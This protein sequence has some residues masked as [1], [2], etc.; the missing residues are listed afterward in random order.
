MLMMLMMMM[1]MMMMMM[2]FFEAKLRQVAQGA[3]AH[4]SMNLGREV[5]HQRRM[6]VP[7]PFFSLMKF[8]GLGQPGGWSYGPL[9]FVSCHLGVLVF[10]SVPLVRCPLPPGS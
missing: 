9:G 5:S 4:S 3:L 7:P 1:M 10:A 8:L 6:G 2:L